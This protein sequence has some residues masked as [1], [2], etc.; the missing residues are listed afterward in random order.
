MGSLIVS[1]YMLFEQDAGMCTFENNKLK[2][3]LFDCYCCGCLVPCTLV[4]DTRQGGG[5]AP[6]TATEMTR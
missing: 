1:D 6:P 5:G 3:T 4:Y 2:I